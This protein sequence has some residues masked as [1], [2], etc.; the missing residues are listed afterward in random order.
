MLVDRNLSY[1]P[2]EVSRQGTGF[3]FWLGSDSDS[4]FEATAILEVS[5]IRRGT[6]SAVRRRVREK[7]A[8]VEKSLHLGL[9][10]Y[11]S[12]IEFGTPLA[13]VHTP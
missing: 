11:V 1:T 2:I 4:L 7:L 9:A 6:A 5:G 13:E 8:Q 3:D 10:T 12:V